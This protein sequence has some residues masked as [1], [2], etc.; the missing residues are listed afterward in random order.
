MK[1]VNGTG[2]VLV[3][4]CVGVMAGL[5]VADLSFTWALSAGC[6]VMSLADGALRLRSEA[7]G[8]E[9]WLTGGEGG[10][11]GRMPVWILGIV[12]LIVTQTGL[13]ERLNGQ[14]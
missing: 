13:I 3:L 7:T 5:A 4:I 11:F 10:I 8:K 9:K 14:G 12:L 6:V 2:V 1:R